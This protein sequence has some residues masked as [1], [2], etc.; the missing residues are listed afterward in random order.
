MAQPDDLVPTPEQRRRHDL[1]MAGF[2][3][4]DQA[5]AVFD[6]T[7]KLVTWNKALLRLLDFP[8]S[9]VKVGT[10]FEA[11][12]RFNAERGE[13]GPGDIEKLVAARMASARSFEPHY[14]ERVRP[15]GKVLAVRGVPIPNLGFVSL[16][17]DVTEQRRAEALVQE[18][19]ARLEARVRERTAELEQANRE[20]DQIAG[21]LRLSEGRMRLILDAIPAMI[22]HVDAGRRYRFANR[23]YAEWFGLTKE[24]IVGR[25]I[26]DV[27]GEDT[28]AAIDTYL[29]EAETGERVSYEYARRNA[30]GQLVHARSVV[31]PDV[32]LEGGFRGY[33][34]MSIDITEQKA[35]QAALVQAQKM[36]AVGQLT[37]GLAHDFNNL[38]TII[39]G[40]LSAL[41]DKLAGGDGAEYV[42]PSLQA[43]RRGAELI[44]RLLGFSRRQ[45]LEPAAVEVGGLVR[46]MTQLLVRT[47]GETITVRQQYP[48]API[49]ALADPH[50][51]ENAI[52]NLAIN[53]R[54]A[55]SGGGKLTIT[56]QPRHISGSLARLSEVPPGDYVQIDVSDTG[57][58][59]EPTVL[60]RVFEPFFTTK[61]FGGG[62][63]LGLSM[64]YGFVRQSGGNIRILSTPGKGT[65]VRFVLPATQPSAPARA[66]ESAASVPAA[67]GCGP[68]LLVEDEPE[69][70]KVIRMQLTT[71]G[72]PVIEAGDGVEA[73]AL[74]ENIENIA[75]LVSDTVM[76]G[77]LNGHELAR[78]ARALRP[79]LPILLITGYAS[80]RP[81]GDDAVANIPVLRKPFD[82]PALA[83]ALA[84]LAA[85]ADA[86]PTPTNP[87][88]EESPT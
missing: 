53:A 65:N 7:P 57:K 25:S 77:G 31:V 70:R 61:P 10:P 59:I 44:R 15:N 39:I 68:V 79:A 46:N 16:W 85:G 72:Y 22:A 40:N 47:L 26:E 24:K 33:F 58:G 48:D 54:D 67:R 66:Q 76:P 41:Q 37:G 69:V 27:F 19:N 80:E 11:F 9:L 86:G 14:V 13:Y 45:T 8:E 55:M 52:L 34:V 88:K 60:A 82:P 18:Q 71:L 2:D 49:H 5:I 29:C 30:E 3:L 63:G 81:A 23:A 32:S 50:Q 36:E 1:L 6:A 62:S 4:L 74:L 64:V 20:I 83:T 84:G 42:D 21:A 75:V 35:S 38:L 17:T 78:R 43:A 87:A 28:Y 73:L 56:V 51:L 12:V